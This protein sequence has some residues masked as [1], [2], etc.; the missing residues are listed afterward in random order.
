MEHLLRAARCSKQQAQEVLVVDFSRYS[1]AYGLTHPGS[2]VSIKKD[3]YWVE[4]PN[5][6]LAK[7]G[8]AI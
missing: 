8:V 6:L 1:D 5:D 2:V 4:D 3:A 7:Y